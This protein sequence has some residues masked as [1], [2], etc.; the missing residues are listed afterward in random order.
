MASSTWQRRV[1]AVGATARGICEAFDLRVARGDEHV[2][3][4][5]YIRGIVGDRIKQ[6]TRD[7]AEPGPMQDVIDACA[8]APTVFEGPHVAF[9]KAEVGPLSRADLGLH[10]VQVALIS[11]GEVVKTHHAL[12]ELQQR[13]QQIRAGEAGDTSDQLGFR[14]LDQLPTKL[15]VIGHRCL[16]YRRMSASS[17]SRMY[18]RS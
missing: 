16:T 2:Q 4:A 1:V 3:K 17:G 9:Y 15:F 18:F 12:V 10:F 14:L 7:V 13:F 5:A 8:G 6:A 11:G